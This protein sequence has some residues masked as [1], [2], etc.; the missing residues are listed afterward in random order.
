MPSESEVGLI[1]AAIR[2]L[3]E[4]SAPDDQRVCHLLLAALQ[5]RG[6]RGDVFH[7]LNAPQL[8]QLRLLDSQS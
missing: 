1:G 3:Q 6:N 4:S 8:Y 5:I 7:P 2:L